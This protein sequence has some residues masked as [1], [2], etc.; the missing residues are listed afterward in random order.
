M[1]GTTVSRPFSKPLITGAK[2]ISFILH[3]LFVGVMMMYYI[4][5]LH[6][7]I[8]I[9]VS[10]K[11]RFYKFLTFVVNNVMFPV[12]VVLLLKGLG[13]TKSIILNTQKERIIPYVASIIFFFN[14]YNTFRNQPDSPEILTDMC[15]GIFL[16]VCLALVLNN[17]SKISMHAIGIGGMLGLAIVIILTG[18]AY[19]IWPLTAAVLLTGLVCTARLIVSD[20]TKEDL[21]LGLLIGIGTQ[22]FAWWL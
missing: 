17:F 15:Q 11:G 6:P 21:V 5:Y 8:F 22:I 7:T 14:S 4:T 18:Q 16:S 12:L 9:A 10:E 2:I 20:H 3:P 1:T 19:A 13:F